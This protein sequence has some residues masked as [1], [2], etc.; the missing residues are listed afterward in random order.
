MNKKLLF[1]HVLFVA[2]LIGLSSCGTTDTVTVVQNGP[3]TVTPGDTAAADTDEEFQAITV[4]LIDPVE[5]FDPLFADNLSTMRVLSLIYDGLFTLDQTGD[6]VPAIADEVSVSDDGLEY[7]IQIKSNLFFHDG[8]AFQSGIGRQ[9]QASDIKWAFERTAQ[10]GVPSTASKLL[11]NI[12]GYNNY[13][14]EQRELFEDRKQILDEV[15]GIIVEDPQTIVFVLMEPDDN[16]TRKLASPYLYI[17]PQEAV[18]TSGE[19]LSMEPVGTGSYMFR[20]KT[21]SGSMTLSLDTSEHSEARIE[22]PQVDRVDFVGGTPER[23][24]FQQFARG[25]IHWIPEIGPQISLQVTDGDGNLQSTYDDL[26]GVTQTGAERTNYF[27]FHESGE[28]NVLWLKDR[29][30][31]VDL[32]SID[33]HATFEMTEEPENL[34]I[35]SEPDS[36]YL[37]TYTDDIY[38][39]SLLSTLQNDFMDSDISLSLF[40]IRVP[41]NQTAMYT[42]NGDSFHDSLFDVESNFWVKMSSPITSLYLPAVTGIEENEVPWKLFMESVR[43]PEQD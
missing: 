6:V 1:R 19:N 23:T 24:L 20:E 4:G 21:D 33:L 27:Y 35:T 34:E 38:A 14:K 29:L 25:D 26:Y 8:S 5:N 31:N 9:L 42:L 2:L 16:F 43:V 37:V 22:Q 18:Q 41:T 17:Y 11:T 7:R 40:E 12:E 39:R 28:T 15:S 13:A 10:A 32:S 3:Q 36:S 30:Y